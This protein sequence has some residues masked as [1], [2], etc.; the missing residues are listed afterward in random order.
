M[1]LFNVC[2]TRL[3]ALMTFVGAM[4]YYQCMVTPLLD[5]KV[6]V[7]VNKNLKLVNISMSPEELEN[8]LA[9]QQLQVHR[10]SKDH[11]N[12]GME[13]EGKLKSPTSV[14]P[15]SPPPPP[16]HSSP[17][18]ASP[19]KALEINLKPKSVRPETISAYLPV[20]KPSNGSFLDALDISSNNVE[21][22]GRAHLLMLVF[23][24]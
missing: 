7:K 10:Q 8:Y 13:A 3:V 24:A 19:I 22:F 20:L 6:E 17:P 14:S 18:P 12:I 9:L 5:N 15:P 11:L 4:F 2:D 1:R 23:V 21:V 16:R